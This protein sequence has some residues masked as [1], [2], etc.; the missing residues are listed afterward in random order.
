MK[1]EFFNNTI[2]FKGIK[3]A[4]FIITTERLLKESFKIDS[5]IVKIKLTN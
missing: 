2:K 4:G 3:I 5:E 1:L